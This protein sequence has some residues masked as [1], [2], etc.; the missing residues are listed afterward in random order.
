M[1]RS[2]AVGKGT[3]NSAGDRGGDRSKGRG[4][5]ALS[6][7]RRL[8]LLD[9]PSI[10]RTAEST[11][12]PLWPDNR[13]MLQRTSADTESVDRLQR[14]LAEAVDQRR[15][16]DC[17]A[18]IQSDAVQLSLDLLVR[19]PDIDGFFRAFIRT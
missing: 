16:A 19:E 18:R 14:D 4:I 7:D 12:R 17:M 3:N 13:D 5:H 1:H 8:V 15:R 2:I 10:G 11:L 6:R 9:D